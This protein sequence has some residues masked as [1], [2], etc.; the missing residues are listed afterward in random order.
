MPSARCDYPYYLPVLSRLLCHLEAA[1]AGLGLGWAEQ[2]WAGQGEPPPVTG[3]QKGTDPPALPA[4][5]L[6][7]VVVVFEWV[8][9]CALTPPVLRPER[10]FV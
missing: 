10:S 1:W 2:G 3:C 7:F 4:W 8:C 6:D 9:V 5:R